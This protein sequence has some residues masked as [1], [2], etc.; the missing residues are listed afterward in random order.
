MVNFK[1]WLMK[2]N[3]SIVKS[4]V[5]NASVYNTEALKKETQFCFYSS[6]DQ[7]MAKKIACFS[8]DITV[9][10]SGLDIVLFKF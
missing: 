4:R 3:I 1:K 7:A 6:Y 2:P 5:K 9:I 10:V 8:R